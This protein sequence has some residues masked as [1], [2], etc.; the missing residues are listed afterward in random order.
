MVRA[1]DRWGKR[2][3]GL[4]AIP[5]QMKIASY[6]IFDTCITRSAYVPTEL[7]KKVG[8]RIA[9]LEREGEL[10]SFA[11]NF[12]SWRI[13]SE[14]RVR[15][16]AGAREVTLSEIWDELRRMAGSRAGMIEG[17]RLEMEAEMDSLGPILAIVRD[18]ESKRSQGQRIIF[19]SDI[20][21]PQAFVQRVLMANGIF[22]EGDGLYLSSETGLT[23]S[24]GLL[25]R[26]VLDTERI[27]A[28][29]IVH[30]GD[31]PHSDIAPA[32]ALGIRTVLFSHPRTPF[33]EQLLVRA[34]PAASPSWLEAAGSLRYRRFSG[35]VGWPNGDVSEFVEDFLG[36][37]CCLFG[38]WVLGRARADRVDR[39]FFAA[40]DA[41]L[42]WK[43]CSW[44]CQTENIPLDCRYLQ[45]SGKALH[46]PS[47]VELSA[48]GL[49]WLR[50]D[51]ENQAFADLTSDLGLDPAAWE[52]AW[53]RWQPHVDLA[54]PLKSEDDWR[55][56]FSFIADP[57]ASAA[58]IAA[59]EKRRRSALEYLG[60]AGFL[61]KPR[62]GLVDLGWALSGQG[63]LWRICS[64]SA[65]RPDVKG[66]YLGLRPIRLGP[67]EAGSAEGMFSD[68]GSWG[69]APDT[70]SWVAR[71]SVVDALL[72]WPDG[73]TVES[74]DEAG[75]PT[76]NESSALEMSSNARAIEDALMD[77]VR[78]YHADWAAFASDAA[79]ARNFLALLITR[80]VNSPPYSGPGVGKSVQ[81][82]ADLNHKRN[83]LPLV[84]PLG[85]TDVISALLPENASRRARACFGWKPRPIWHEASILAST[86]AT[87]L[88]LRV[89]QFL[90]R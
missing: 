41:R 66:Y 38:N 62:C 37:V 19:V 6:D 54:R 30:T 48:D 14:R 68:T 22:R 90:R 74:Y 20:Y 39:L 33:A 84:R 80:F 36:P 3:E 11:E 5:N 51:W 21:L 13:E 7:F 32:Q 18:V 79:D 42:L 53:R 72:G 40:R 87:R 50:R 58:I 88:G 71:V 69:V 52:T 35:S 28:G 23:K 27:E 2:P 63:A 59:I 10:S 64:G 78:Q 77:Y 45:I 56:Y 9:G 85:W 89:A 8:A 1:L 29:E 4:I 46:L 65:A 83:P 75:K 70:L 55:T 44:I 15:R 49:N 16:R 82:F 67:G 47:T 26:H 81:R 31:N 25:F 57:A 17:E 86:T 73:P 12:P 43:A 60:Q 61:E 76:F 24:S 34:R